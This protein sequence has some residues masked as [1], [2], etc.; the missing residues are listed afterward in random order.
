MKENCSLDL[1]AN[2]NSKNSV[3]NFKNPAFN[4]QIIQAYDIGTISNCFQANNC[5]KNATWFE[6][7]YE[8]LVC[9]SMY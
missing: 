9:T 2:Y 4:W 5:A 1:I 8:L 7:L 3:R 6:Y